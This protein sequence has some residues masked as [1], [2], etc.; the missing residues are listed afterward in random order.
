MPKFFNQPLIPDYSQNISY[1][2]EGRQ[3]YIGIASPGTL[4]S[5]EKWQ[6]YILTYDGSGRMITRRYANLARFNV[7]W[8]LR[9]NA[10][11]T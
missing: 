1:D 11:Y 6:V 2:S 4:N 10:T 7:K 9:S 3:Q 5:E 8:T